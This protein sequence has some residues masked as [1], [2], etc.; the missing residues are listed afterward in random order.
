VLMKGKSYEIKRE[1][2]TAGTFLWVGS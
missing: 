2:T 1:R